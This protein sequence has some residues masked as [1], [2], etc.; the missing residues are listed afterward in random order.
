MVSSGIT[1]IGLVEKRSFGL[2]EVKLGL[3]GVAAG[4]FDAELATL[5][6]LYDMPATALPLELDNCS[7]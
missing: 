3:V 2:I 7:L 1:V 5:A 4:L 6:F